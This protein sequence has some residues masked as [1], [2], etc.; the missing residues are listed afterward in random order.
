MEHLPLY[1]P[2]T[3]VL[4]TLLTVILLYKAGNHSKPLLIIILLWLIVQA[5]V[6]LSGFYTIST[7]IPPRFALLLVPSTLLIVLLL[8]TKQG[9]LFIDGFDA[10]T[11][12]LIHIVRVPVEIT[13]YWLFLHK[14]VPQLMTFEGRNFDILC[15]L[16]AP[17][18]YYWGHIKNSL[19]KGILLAWNIACLLFLANIVITAILSAPFDFQ[20][21]AFSQPN[22]ALFYF[23]FIWLPCFVVPTALLAHIVNIRKIIT[24][25]K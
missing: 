17:I 18:I 20:K 7:G 3:F 24:H 11:L 5:A 16:T 6:G 19:S 12:T 10:K 25:K 2:I 22:I 13:L 1:I 23:P 21:V 9:R 14:A 15:G 4:T 8:I